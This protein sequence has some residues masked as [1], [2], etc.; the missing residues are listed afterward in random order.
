MGRIVGF[1][2]T[3][4]SRDPNAPRHTGEVQAIYL[5]P[6]VIGK[7]IGR[8][9]FAYAVDDLRA[10][11][12]TQAALWVLSTNTR[13]RRF[14]EAAGWSHDGATKMEERP[15]AVLHEVR[16]SVKLS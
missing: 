1:A 7:G 9:L 3:G 12:Y 4:A 6:Q 10:R 2:I 8:A 16:Y 14:Y 5:D 15:G 11:G 13:A